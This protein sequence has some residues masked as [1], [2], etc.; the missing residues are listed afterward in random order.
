MFAC[1]CATPVIHTVSLHDA[2]PI[3]RPDQRARRGEGDRDRSHHDG[4]LEAQGEGRG[5]RQEDRPRRPEARDRKSTR[6]NSSHRLTPY[7]VFC[8]IKKHTPPHHPTTS[9][10]APSP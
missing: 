7:A 8:C 6:L 9:A 5:R 2:L 1:A 4:R 3:Y 10:A